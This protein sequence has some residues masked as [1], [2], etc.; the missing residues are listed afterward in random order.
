[1][2]RLDDRM[3]VVS[4]GLG[5]GTIPAWI[6]IGMS[7]KSIGFGAK[8]A[9]MVVDG[10]VESRE[11]FRPLCLPSGEYFGSC[12]VLQILVVGDHED[13]MVCAFQV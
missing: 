7:G 10:V 4:V 1:M 9:G 8:L 3:D 13:Y 5:V 11:V 6:H 12:E 2:Q